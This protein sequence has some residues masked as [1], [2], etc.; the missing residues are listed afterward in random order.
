MDRVNVYVWYSLRVPEPGLRERKK[1][2]TRAHIADIATTAFT[3]RGFENVTVAEIAEAAGVSKMTVFNYFP[4]KE[5]LFLDRH[6][7]R[8][9]DLEQAITDRPSGMSVVAVMH[10]HQHDLLAGGHPLSGVVAGTVSFFT[11]LRS[12]PALM[13]RRQEQDR[14][15]DDALAAVLVAEFGESPRTRLAGAL[16][17]ATVRTIFDTAVARMLAGGTEEEVRRAQ[18]TVID[19]AFALLE[20]GI[21]DVGA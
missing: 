19:E 7:E 11:V 4:R 13:S 3:R 14:E 20:N 21:G 9:T 12:S 5:D 2:A 8:L 6:A 18:A 17:G 1:Q 15:I 16:L 10:R